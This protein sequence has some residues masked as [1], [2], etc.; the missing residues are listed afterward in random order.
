V[1]VGS[2]VVVGAGVVVVGSGVVVVV[3]GSGVVVTGKHKGSK[4]P[5]TFSEASRSK[6]YDGP[7]SFPMTLQQFTGEIK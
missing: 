4:Q 7:K 1:V 2:G 3:V 5:D 6:S